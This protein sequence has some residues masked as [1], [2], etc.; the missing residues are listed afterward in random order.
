MAV[1]TTALLEALRT[2]LRMEFSNGFK[3][4]QP[5]T[6]WTKVATLVPS[7]SGSNTYGWLGDWPNLIEWVGA[8]TVKDLKEFGYEIQN[9]LYEAT[10]AIPRV[11]IEDD[12]IGMYGP[13][14][15]GMGQAAARHPDILI[16]ALIAA[17]ETSLGPDGQNYFDTDHPVYPNHD[18][19]GVATTASNITA[20]AATPWYLFDCS[21]PLKPLIFQERTKPEFEAKT[22]AATS[23]AV[24]TT[25]TYQYGIRYRCNAGYGFWQMAHKA[26]VALD[27]TS[28]NTA[29]AGMMSRKADGGRPLGIMPTHL[30]V[31]PSLRASAN[32]VIERMLGDGGASNPNYK[33]V[34]VIVVPWLA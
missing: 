22:N 7:S 21:K 33:A 9:K 1:I 2:N 10:V 17:G 24:F 18:G 20:G 4:M 14:A 11:Q 25:D 31:P 27:E 26:K 15:A 8:R 3:A 32:N 19:T 12:N 28:F 30:V 6:F 23:D 5:Q 13:Q 16:A 34:E 29:Y